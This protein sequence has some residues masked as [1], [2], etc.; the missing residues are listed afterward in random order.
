MRTGSF[1][2]CFWLHAYSLCY[3][4]IMFLAPT[5]VKLAAATERRAAAWRGAWLWRQPTQQL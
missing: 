2:E 3:T 4:L 1:P 5:S